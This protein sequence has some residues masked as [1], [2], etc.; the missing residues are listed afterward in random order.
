MRALTTVTRKGS[1]A[2]RG[3]PAPIAAAGAHS[4]RVIAAF[5]GWQSRMTYGRWP[6][7]AQ[8][9]NPVSLFG[10]LS[11]AIAIAN[12]A[13]TLDYSVTAFLA[14]VDDCKWRY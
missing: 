12:Q 3:D 5:R 1:W 4:S 11:I 14:T 2:G 13:Q 7:R 8:R 9:S 10:F 6:W